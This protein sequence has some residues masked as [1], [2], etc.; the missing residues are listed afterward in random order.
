MLKIYKECKFEGEKNLFRGN[1][2]KK[3]FKIKS[4]IKLKKWIATGN[5]SEKYKQ[6]K[7]NYKIRNRDKLRKSGLEYYYRTRVLKDKK[8]AGC[9]T[10]NMDYCKSLFH[11]KFCKKC[12]IKKLYS[13]P[14]YRLRMCISG[15]VRYYI[16]NIG[17]SKNKNSILKYLPYTI[18][19]LKLYLESLFE[20]WMNWN[21]W[22]M[23]NPHTWND[24][25]P[26]TWI[27]QIDHRIPQSKLHYKSMDEE[28]FK[29]CWA[30]SNLRPLSAKQN[31]MK[32][33]RLE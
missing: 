15:T 3:C 32:R 19:E 10:C 1:F 31:N 30:L 29:L 17:G 12:Y 33:D 9:K 22:G 27:W 5:N 6:Q 14:V 13:D 21:N 23:Y 4:A 20:S 11:G 28:N 26:S 7:R 8:H 18:G 24:N 25:D 2:C 16:K